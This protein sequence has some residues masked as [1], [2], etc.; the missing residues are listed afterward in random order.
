MRFEAR[1]GVGRSAMA[2]DRGH[3]GQQAVAYAPKPLC[4]IRRAVPLC[5][6]NRH[7]KRSKLGIRQGLRMEPAQVRL[8]QPPILAAFFILHGFVIAKDSFER[9]HDSLRGPVIAVEFL[10]H[11]AEAHTLG[12]TCRKICDAQK[13]GGFVV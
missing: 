10:F 1:L 5:P 11:I 6:L 8:G 7:L 2:E 9:S 13:I 3:R 4:L 12:L